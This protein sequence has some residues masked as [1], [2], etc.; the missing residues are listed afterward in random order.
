M[1]EAKFPPELAA[2]I[3]H[4]RLCLEQFGEDDPRSIEAALRCML[5]LPDQA[6]RELQEIA[7]AVGH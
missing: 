1:I 5:L 4:H 6:F 7:N 3:E 2:A